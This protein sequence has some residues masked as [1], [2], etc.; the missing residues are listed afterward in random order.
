MNAGKPVR[1][2]RYERLL[3]GLLGLVLLAGVAWALTDG[4][5]SPALDLLRWRS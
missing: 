1:F 2:D 4:G 5:T 3:R